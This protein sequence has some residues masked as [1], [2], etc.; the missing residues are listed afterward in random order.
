MKKSLIILGNILIILAVLAAVFLDVS[1]EQQWRME[2]KREDFENMTAAMENVTN[3]VSTATM[4]ILTLILIFFII[5]TSFWKTRDDC[6]WLIIRMIY[7]IY[8]IYGISFSF[9]IS[10]VFS[11]SHFLSR[12]AVGA[13]PLLR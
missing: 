2:T 13:N 12:S 8:S 7:H 9:I 5:F 6:G 4:A 11:P 1:S 10:F 3:A